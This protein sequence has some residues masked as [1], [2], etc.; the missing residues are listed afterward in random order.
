MAT[1]V[2]NPAPEQRDSGMGWIVGMV[3]LLAFIVLFFMYGLPYLSRSV[4][5]TATQ[6]Q[7]NI[8]DKVNVNVQQQPKT[9]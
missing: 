6:P 7:V 4:N 1:T 5:S 3:V 9:Q 2:V 8:P